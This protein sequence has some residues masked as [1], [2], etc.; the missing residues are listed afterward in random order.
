[1]DVTAGVLQ[2]GGCPDSIDVLGGQSALCCQEVE[3]DLTL[4]DDLLQKKRD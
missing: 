1:M 4:L 2:L 3:N